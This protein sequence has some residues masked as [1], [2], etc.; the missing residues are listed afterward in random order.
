MDAIEDTIK[1][2]SGEPFGIVKHVLNFDEENKSHMLNMIQYSL[3]AV[4]P[5]LLILKTT[6]NVFPEEDESKGNIEILAESIGQIVMLILSIWFIHKFIEY[7]P[8]YSGNPYGDF[9]CICYIIPFL[10]LLL[11]MQTKLGAKLNILL[12]RANEAWYGESQNNQKNHAKNNDSVRISQPGISSQMPPLPKH[13]PSK[14][15]TLDVSQL[16][17]R[18]V[19]TSIPETTKNYNIN[20][21]I[22]QNFGQSQGPSYPENRGQQTQF[23]PTAANDGNFGSPW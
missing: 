5:I 1:S 7:I 19:N 2:S 12:D 14:A 11:T 22:D 13:Q 15:D 3:L 21:V 18:N 4:V 9:N 23:E 6:K 16:I 17:P 10:L 8:T 20:Q